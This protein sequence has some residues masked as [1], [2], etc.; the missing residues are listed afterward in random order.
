MSQP[1][2]DSFRPTGPDDRLDALLASRPVRP[3]TGL[4]DR[5]LAEI[6]REK[7]AQDDALD[8]LLKAAPTAVS[9]GFAE[10]VLQAVSRARRRRLI[11]RISAPLAAAAC[12]ALAALPGL[13]GP[14]RG[15]S[16]P[17]QVAAALAADAELSALAALP[18]AKNGKEALKTEDL[19]ALAGLGNLFPEDSLDH[20]L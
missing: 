9:P 12:L 14:G 17:D 8:R 10:R 5:V 18:V 19:A 16:G 3:A 2:P 1:S 4:A 20:A 11:F 13:H 15:L 7:R 6:A